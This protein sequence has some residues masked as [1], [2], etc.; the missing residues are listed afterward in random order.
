[1]IEFDLGIMFIQKR[2]ALLETNVYVDITILFFESTELYNY[3]Y[4][5]YLYIHFQQRLI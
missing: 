2:G 4:L 1:V 5:L 3:T